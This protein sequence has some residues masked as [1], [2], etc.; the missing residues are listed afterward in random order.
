MTL[1]GESLSE[2]EKRELLAATGGLVRLRG[3][4]VEVDGE[5]LAAALTHWKRVERDARSGGVSFYEGMR[6]LAGASDARDAIEEP[7]QPLREWSGIEAGEALRQVL[8]RLRDPE[9]EAELSLKGLRATLRPYQ[10]SGAKWLA[11]LTSLG[12]GACLADDMGLGKTI[13][14]L[15]LLSHLRVQ[16]APKSAKAAGAISPSVASSSHPPSLIVAPASLIANWK[17]EIER[18]APALT[19]FVAHPSDCSID[20]N[21]EQALTESLNEVALV[22]TTYGVITRT[23]ALRQTRWDLIVLD[24]AQAIKNAGA[25][26]TRAVKQL[27]GAGRIALTGRPSR[28]GS[29][30]S[31][32][33]LIS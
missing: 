13:Q 26:Q 1:G 8:A 10:Q 11:L 14:V 29:P 4:W 12:L 25:Q 22:I 17:A 7:T 21:N 9:H 18:F 2:A 32:P 27:V 20:L 23:A 3:Q 28:I 33:C 30:T 24:E 31:G 5:K 15:A 6:L 16:R 19:V